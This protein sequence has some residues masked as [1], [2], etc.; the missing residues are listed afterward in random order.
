[1]KRFLSLLLVL[2]LLLT[3]T[4]CHNDTAEPTDPA[5]PTT[6]P[7]TATQEA[8]QGV[9]EAPD[10]NAEAMEAYRS[11]VAALADTADIAMDI[12]YDETLTVGSDTFEKS[13]S[14]KITYL[15]LGTDDLRATVSETLQYDEYETDISEVYMDGVAYANVYGSDFSSEITGEDFI[16]RYLPVV[17]LDETLYATCSTV[18]SDAGFVITF[19]DALALEAWLATEAKTLTHADAEVTIDAQ[20]KISTIR[21]TAEYTNMGGAAR[22]EVTVSFSDPAATQISVPSGGD[23]Y[24]KLTYLDGPRM[25]EHIY[26]Y[27][28][29]AKTVTHSSKTQVVIQAANLVTITNNTINSVDSGASLLSEIDYSYNASDLYTG[30]TF[31]YERT[32]RFENGKYTISTDGGAPTADRS[33]TASV[34]R[35]YILNAI[36]AEVYDCASFTDAVCTDLGDLLLIEFTGSE[37]LSKTIK[38]Y[39]GTTYLGD[40]KLLDNYATAYRNDAMEYY[41][42]IDKN[43]GLPTA[44][45]IHFSG[46]HTIDGY[47]YL[48]DYQVDQSIYLASLSAYYTIT[49]K[50]APDTEPEETATPVFYHVTGADGQELW[51]LGTIHVGDDRTGFLPQEIY[52]AFHGADALAVE[53]NTRTFE[54]EVEEDEKLQE[55]LSKLYFY[56]DGSTIKDHIEDQELYELALKMM[57]ATGNY[58]YNAPYFQLP[59]WSDSIDSYSLQQCYTLSSD[60][61]VDNRLMILAEENDK[62]ILEVESN[63]SQLEMLTGWS[64]ELSLLLLEESVNASGLHYLNGLEEMYA[65]WCA[66]DEA[67]LRE[68]L[69]DDTSDLTDEELKLYEE[70]NNAMGPDRDKEMIATAISYLESGDTVFMAVGLAHVLSDNSL[71]DGLREAGYTVELVQYQ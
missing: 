62:K 33:I 14:Q 15:G 42:G 34:V 4:G 38:E 10:P 24:T 45:G 54:E 41:I 48:L 61:G 43:L 7:T 51:L 39:L 59:L 44:I 49:E 31:N 68:F 47:E 18:K 21:Y 65:L 60:K 23:K 64:E 58:F 12:T 13:S 5:T 8:T 11:A 66:G 46:Y 36:T 19:T 17:L 40:A 1:M 69:K 50:S 55:Q 57:K 37:D 35:E 53:C 30:E 2:C 27:L 25:L 16:S 56:T 52:D 9:T 70:Y 3:V 71:V 63:M 67:A 28:L 22:T 6:A 29:Q 20:G 26:G 32:E